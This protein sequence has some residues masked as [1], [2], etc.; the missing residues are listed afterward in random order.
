MYGG[1]YHQLQ[2]ILPLAGL[3][4]YI[5]QPTFLERTIGN[6]AG[7]DKIAGKF[8]REKDCV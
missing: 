1:N 6:T 2:Y 3:F 7:T 5:W 4:E 8:A